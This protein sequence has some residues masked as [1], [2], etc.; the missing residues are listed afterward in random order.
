MIL[1]SGVIKMNDDIWCLSIEEYGSLIF[2]KTLVT[3]HINYADKHV[4]VR[5]V[6]DSNE[7]RA[8]YSTENKLMMLFKIGDE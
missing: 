5:D 4:V 1:I 8:Y 6:R 2:S 7:Y 3:L